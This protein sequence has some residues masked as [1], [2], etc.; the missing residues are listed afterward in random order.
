MN[1]QTK[2]YVHKIEQ[3]IEYHKSKYEAEHKPIQQLEIEALEFILNEA[4]ENLKNKGI[5]L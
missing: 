5:D 4:K 2:F 1:E 3:S